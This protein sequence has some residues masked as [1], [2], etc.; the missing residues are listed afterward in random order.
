MILQEIRVTSRSLSAT[1]GIL[2][3][4]ETRF[5]CAIGRGGMSARKREGDG[6]TPLGIFPLRRLFYRADRRPRPRTG[7]A[8]LALTPKTGWCEDPNDVNYNKLVMLSPETGPD[9]GQ[10]RMWR[11]DHLYDIVVE[12]GYNDDPA[13]KGRGS[14]IF[15]HLARPAYAPTAGCVALSSGDIDHLLPRLGRETVIRIG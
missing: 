11:A 9:T 14:A 4:G 6:T 5:F 12:I 1:T 13:I 10:D 7:L 2:H 3:A 8:T 15:L